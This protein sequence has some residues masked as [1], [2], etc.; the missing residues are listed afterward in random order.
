MRRLVSHTNPL[1]SSGMWL[2]SSFPKSRA[3]LLAESSF[4]VVVKVASI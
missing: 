1:V 2:M 4:Q 3:E